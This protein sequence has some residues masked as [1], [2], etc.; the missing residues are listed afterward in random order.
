MEAD[1]HSLGIGLAKKEKRSLKRYMK[2]KSKTK[3]EDHCL[4]NA[5]SCNMGMKAPP[6]PA[7]TAKLNLAL[8]RSK[9]DQLGIC[10]AAMS[11]AEPPQRVASRHFQYYHLFTIYLEQL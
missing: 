8:Q 6:T 2:K 4:R 5:S 7:K 9:E 11:P 1:L 10:T 3:F